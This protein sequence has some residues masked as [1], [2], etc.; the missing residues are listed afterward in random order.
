MYIVV[1]STEFGITQTW[2]GPP[3]QLLMKTQRKI[4]RLS[5]PNYENG[6]RILTLLV[7]LYVVL[8]TNKAIGT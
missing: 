1:K 6:I 4:S 5:F 2:D 3:S 8:N 7:V